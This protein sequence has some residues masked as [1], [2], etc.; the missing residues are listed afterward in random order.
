MP[1]VLIRLHVDEQGRVTGHAPPG[2]P[3]G[4][5]AVPIELPA[6]V[7]PASRPKLDLPVHDEPWNDSI[8]LRREDL[9]GDDGR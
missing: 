4:D 8:S 3:A 9:Y 5:Y 2:V 6:G 7:P 1:T